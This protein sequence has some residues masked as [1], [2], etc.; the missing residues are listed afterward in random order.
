MDI[1]SVVAGVQGKP[2]RTGIMY[3]VTF[4]D[5]TTAATKKPELATKAQGLIAQQVDARI[6][7]KQNGQYLNRY[8]DDIAP[9]GQLPVAIPMAGGGGGAAAPGIPIVGG[10]GGGR[11]GAMDPV[12]ESKIVKQ[13]VMSTA[14]GFVGSVFSG[15]GPEALEEATQASL[16]L[17]K[18]L[19]A[20]VYGAANVAAPAPV[21]VAQTPEAVA[22]AVNATVGSEAVSVGTAPK[23]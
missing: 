4:A 6:T 3:E 23:W 8:L 9:A 13:S 16:E 20:E 14:F 15:G 10:S 21:V 11:G 19:Y 18:Q 1:S 7:E 2:T 22:A 17:A 12:R 5:G